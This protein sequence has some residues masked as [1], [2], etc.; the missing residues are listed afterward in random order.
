MTPWKEFSQIE[1]ELK[2]NK[3][4]KIIVI[5]PHRILHIK[6]NKNIK[7]LTLGKQN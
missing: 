2:Q 6:K 5:D 1:K 3:N 7:Y 4:K